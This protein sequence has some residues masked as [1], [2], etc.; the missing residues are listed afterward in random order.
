LL[1][2]VLESESTP[3]WIN[4]LT[5]VRDAAQKKNIPL[6]I[7]SANPDKM[8]LQLAKKKLDIPVFACDFTVIRT[9]S[10]TEP[11]L[12][13]LKAGTIKGKGQQKPARCCTGND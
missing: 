7:A 3:D 13:V 5:K 4:N 1:L 11:T 6:F 2:F 10:R 12:Y 9:A 8:R